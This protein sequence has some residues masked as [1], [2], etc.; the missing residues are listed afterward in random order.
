MQNTHTLKEKDKQAIRH[1][2]LAWFH[3]S[4]RQL[5]WR[6]TYTPYH[7]WISEIMLQQTQME[8]GVDYF[9][10]WIARL[11]DV[12]AV[13]AAT[14]QQILKLWEGLGYYARARNLHRAAKV[15]VNEYR[16]ELPCDMD[17]LVQLPGIGPYTAAAI[18]S[19]ACNVDVPVVDANVLRVYARIFD[20]ETP[21]SQSST[22]KK[23]EALA[24]ELLPQG[25]ARQF[26]QALMDFGGL[27]CLPRNPQCMLCPIAGHCLSNLRS[28]V[29]DRPVTGSAKKTVLIE[30]ATG[31][32]ESNGRIFIQQRQADDIWGGLWEFPGGRIEDGES[33][34]EAVVREFREETGFGIELCEHIVSVVHYYTRYKVI[35]HCYAVRLEKGEVQPIP[36]L[37]GAQQYQW[38]GPEELHEF[39]FPAGH[40]KVLEFIAANCPERLSDPCREL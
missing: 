25:K 29:F 36:V 11:P 33:P 21:I 26:N 23:I 1:K 31:I 9:Q 4:D 24:W 34:E 8:R 12:H 22:R 37:Q 27:V 15:L 3:H 16:G 20:I 14:E 2:L 35:L 28:T 39:G 5:P 40:R 32:L 30:M 7:V 18:A 17:A 38:I 19:I 13:A 10:R 6:K